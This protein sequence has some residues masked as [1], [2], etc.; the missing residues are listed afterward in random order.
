[1]PALVRI[2]EKCHW[3]VMDEQVDKANDGTATA[4]W[5]DFERV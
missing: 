5:P 4:W 3:E 2:L 1:M